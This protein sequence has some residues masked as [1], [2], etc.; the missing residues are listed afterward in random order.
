MQGTREQFLA[1][2]CKTRTLPAP[3]LGEGVEITVVEPDDDAYE[4]LE[5]ADYPIGPDGKMS[6][7]RKGRAV[8]WAIATVRNGDGTPMFTDADAPAL[9]RMPSGLLE[10]ILMAGLDMTSGRAPVEDAAKNS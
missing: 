1:A 10:R 3:E 8:R 5:S 7:V 9:A 6:L 4:A 2:K